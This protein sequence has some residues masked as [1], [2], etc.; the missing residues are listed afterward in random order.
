M[1]DVR[2]VAEA[3]NYLGQ[4]LGLRA[5]IQGYAVVQYKPMFTYFSYMDYNYLNSSAY[6]RPFVTLVRYGGNQPGYSSPGG[7]NWVPVQRPQRD[8]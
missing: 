2:L 4:S 6:Q 3:Y 8:G 5:S 1:E 7:L